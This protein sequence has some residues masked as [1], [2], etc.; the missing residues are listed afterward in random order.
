MAARLHI[1]PSREEVID[2]ARQLILDKAEAAIQQRGRFTLALSGGNTP[3]PLYEALAQ[4]SQP[5]ERWHIFWGDE[6]FVPADHPDSNQGMA[7]DAW[8][9]Q[10]QIPAENI[11]PLETEAATPAAAAAANEAHLREFFA[12]A[13]PQE[14][15]RF[16]LMLL[17]MGEDGHTASLFPKTA[18]LQVCDRWVTVG[19]K[20]DQPRLTLT[21]PVLNQARCVLFVVAGADKNPILQEIFADSSAVAASYPAAIIQPEGELLWMLDGEAG[22]GLGQNGLN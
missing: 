12:A 21:I 19:Q 3:K 9:N 4:E 5:W 22:A 13:S 2:R 18:A 17:G 7:R 8:L 14:W 15:P 10:I 6:R 16:D 20:A 11:H 1:Y